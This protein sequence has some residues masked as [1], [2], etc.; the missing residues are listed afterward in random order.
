MATTYL[1]TNVEDKTQEILVIDVKPHVRCCNWVK[2]KIGYDA[3]KWRRKWRTW[4][5]YLCFF[6]FISTLIVSIVL[7]KLPWEISVKKD[8]L[9]NCPL[10]SHEVK[11]K[12]GE[13]SSCLKQVCFNRGEKQLLNE[14]GYC[15]KSCENKLT[16]YNFDEKIC[17]IECKEGQFYDRELSRCLF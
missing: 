8:A 13:G 14:N 2:K 15:V 7:L 4:K 16:K 11:N 17:E 12:N 5:W 10:Y 6:M 9:G 1:D 3:Y